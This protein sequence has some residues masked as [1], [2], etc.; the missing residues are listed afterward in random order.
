[1][2]TNSLCVTYFL[3][4]DVYNVCFWQF[5]TSEL[6]CSIRGKWQWMST[7][8]CIYLHGTSAPFH[9]EREY[10]VFHTYIL[11]VGVGV[12]SNFWSFILRVSEDLKLWGLEILGLLRQ[13]LLN[14]LSLFLVYENVCI[15]AYWILRLI[16]VNYKAIKLS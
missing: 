15:L 2:L 4:F 8:A 6:S 7:I 10:F 3:D 5:E 1:M 11:N 14:S 13:Y 16:K 9:I 12:S